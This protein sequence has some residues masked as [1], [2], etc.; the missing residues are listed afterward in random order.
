MGR[1]RRA[2]QVGRVVPPEP[3][4]VDLHAHTSRS[5]GLLQPRT[6]VADAAAA[7]I[8][9]LAI[10]DH[11][12]LAGYRELVAP[13]GPPL[14]A[15]LVLIAGVEINAVGGG[16]DVPDGELHIVGLGVDPGDEA[17]EAA[18]AG[19]RDGRRRRFERMAARLRAAGLAVDAQLADLDPATTTRWAG[20]PWPAPSW[21]PASRP[22]SRMRLRGSSAEAD[23][24]TSP[25]R[26]LDRSTRSG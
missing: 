14:P 15:G 9:T 7:G 12:T 2:P 22:A 3:T 5:D 11:D 26:A 18:L 8:R 6:L 25:A 4:V 13:A 16:V 24:A 23:R 21:P 19:Q 1:G 20:P 17:F 10:T